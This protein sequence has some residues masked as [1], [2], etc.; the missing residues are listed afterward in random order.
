MACS[1][2][3]FEN[4]PGFR[5]C[6]SC[7]AALG[8]GPTGEERKVVSV[9]FADLVGFTDRS[10]HLDPEEVRA[11]LRPYYAL[12]RGELERFGGTVEKFIGDA[13]MALFGAPVSH[14]DDAE[15]AVRAALAIRDAVAEANER[16]ELGLDV[17]IA[18]N[19]GE[20]LIA[21]GARPTEGE[22]MA[23]GD[24]V[25]TAFRLQE[26]APAGGILV[27][28][29]T[30]RATE[31]AIDFRE[32]E[33]V[34]VKGK[35]RSLRVW[36]AVE[37]RARVGGDALRRGAAR[38]VGRQ[39]EFELLRAALAGVREE[40]QPRVV[41]LVGV[42]GIGKSRLVAELF[43]LVQGD[44]ALVRW[45][46]GR[47]LPYGEAVS[48]WALA[49][50]TKAEAGILESDAADAA[51]EKLARTVAQL[52]VDESEA[53]W[54]V[55]RLKPLVGLSDE[56]APASEGRAEA[57][58]A[59]RRFLH[60]LAAQRPSVLVFEDLHWADDG[61][62]DFVDE[63]VE[64]LSDVPLLVLATARPELL[65]RRPA[66]GAGK[67]GASTLRLSA[68]DDGAMRELVGE[69]L[70]DSELGSEV[71]A[72][73]G[74]NPL[75]AE[76]YV[77][78]L[79]ERA[80]VT[81]GALPESVQGII[82]AR[83]DGLPSEEKAVL[84]DASVIGQGFWVGAVAQLSGASRWS[85]EEILHRLERK[86]FVRRERRS[87]VAGEPQYGF[88]HVLVRDVAYAQ[89]PRT[90][91]AERHALAAQWI[92][93]LGADRPEDHADLLAHHYVS[94]L[95]YGE[96]T[97]IDTQPLRARAR[98]A[99]EEA[100]DRAYGLRAL[101][102]AA[103]LY[104]AALELSPPDDPRRPGLLFALARARF[105]CD[106]TG[107]DLLEEARAELTAAG[108]L[109]AAAEAQALL[110]WFGWR[111]GRREEAYAR[112]AEARRLIEH[113]PAS[114]AKADV[115]ALLARYS[116]V[117][118]SNDDA[119]ETGRAALAM[120]RALG[121]DDVRASV[122]ATVGVARVATGDLAGLDDMEESIALAEE[123]GSPALVRGYLNL[124]S[125][126]S[127]LGNLRR[128]VE[129]QAKGVQ[130]ARRFGDSAAVLW[131][132][133]EQAFLDYS[134]GRWDQALA[135]VEELLAEPEVGPASYWRSAARQ[136]RG[137]IRLGRGDEE[138]ALDDAACAVELARGLRDPQML[139][140]ALA[141]AA[142]ANG[143]AARTA[144]ADRLAGELLDG[145][146]T[147]SSAVWLP[148]LAR[149][150]RALG[151]S[152]ELLASVGRVRM[153][154]RWVD[155]ATAYASEDFQR[156]AALYDEIG[157]APDEAEARTRAAESL[158]AGGRVRDGER[159]LASALD[160]YRR[161]GAAAY[162]AAAEALRAAAL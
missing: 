81:G 132:R 69:L 155:A 66:W 84:Q 125:T 121:L 17:R 129:P 149:A 142:F 73:A 57:F 10:E 44:P 103:R 89:I 25:N 91:R 15:R 87:A 35:Q 80:P 95:E 114:R 153:P 61:L 70:P 112:I 144:D 3:G 154:T 134:C 151:R 99:L 104:G 53:R 98:R 48:Y 55:S 106:E 157:T 148:D 130:A 43:A 51:G 29:T 19:T 62:L 20:A 12:L 97:G 160:F 86:E 37:A 33:P 68:L 49:E 8:S 159:E 118:D 67:A 27:D 63:L 127:N 115:L 141:F 2:C 131:S 145:W 18:V 78:M 21:L 119:I 140:P 82:A 85:L 123:L 71:A 22:G 39:A 124:G 34:T 4:P 65:D 54:V 58:A 59:W 14:E 52:V 11:Q 88:H 75:Y 102:A 92:E 24:V 143:A 41:T 36:E 150:V 126:Y 47:S 113:A 50:M 111:S 23:A 1:A 117:A 147:S 9:L 32:V 152:D 60:A 7:G 100:G 46:R 146:T 94:A 162:A 139:Y 109:A 16:D 128:A 72:R 56:A 30:R 120:A 76:E 93:T 108:E 38:L 138:G 5:F 42:P 122:L 158:L 90:A 161:V 77:R 83:I 96:T 74:G 107:E 26:A 40:R 105:W 135:L 110:A 64:W 101:E 116:M 31:H 28:E 137:A 45:R 6:G 136:I 79:R 156:A 133:H 13:V